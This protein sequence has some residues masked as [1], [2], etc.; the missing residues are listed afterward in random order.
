MMPG[1]ELTDK[2]AVITGS[3]KGIGKAIAETYAAHGTKVVISSRKHDA[4]VQVADQI[5]GRYGP[6]T[7]IAAAANISDKSALQ[8][9]VDETREA[10]G[11]IDILVCNAAT[12]PHFGPMSTIT[13][14]QFQKILTNNI[15][16]NHW[17]VHMVA[18]Q[19]VE[20]RDGAIIIVT[21]TGGLVGSSTI[22]AYN[23]SKAADM[24][25]VR[26]LAVEFGGANVRVNAI[27]PGTIK[28]EMARVLWDDP[29]LERAMRRITPLGRI[30]EPEDI[31]GAALFLASNASRHMTGQTLVVDGGA[32]IGG[33]VVV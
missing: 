21:S 15:L 12:N 4:C 8:A 29:K 19:M 11:R 24:Q 3:S 17:L 30:G 16:A 14:E 31:A 9:L 1:F 22:G 5:N 25:L 32:T 26:S 28:T 6:R 7:A 13:D 20:R 27:A 10:F 2:V 23:V 33:I 18:P